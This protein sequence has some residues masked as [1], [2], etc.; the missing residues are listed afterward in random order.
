VQPSLVVIIITNNAAINGS[1]FDLHPVDMV[2][3]L[4]ACDVNQ[5]LVI[6]LT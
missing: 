3:H 2:F 1:C 6:L 4:H 5:D